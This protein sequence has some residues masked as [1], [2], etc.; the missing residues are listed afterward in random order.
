MTLHVYVYANIDVCAYVYMCVFEQRLLI[1]CERTHVYALPDWLLVIGY[2][3]QVR[4]HVSHGQDV[5][6]SEPWKM[7]FKYEIKVQL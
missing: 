7:Q 4:E 1:Q 6:N 3:Y 5:Y 2:W